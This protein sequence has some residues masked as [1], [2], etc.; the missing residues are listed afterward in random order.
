MG[1]E[2]EDNPATVTVGSPEEARVVD[3]ILGEAWDSNPR[4]V[5]WVHDQMVRMGVV[6]LDDDED[7][8]S[9]IH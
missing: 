7:S 2:S 3:Q 8:E 1:E 4:A 9:S 5:L 6:E